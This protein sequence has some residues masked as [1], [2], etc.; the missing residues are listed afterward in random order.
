MSRYDCSV[1][2][3]A[4]IRGTALKLAAEDLRRLLQSGSV[5]RET[6]VERFGDDS[7]LLLQG[8][9]D[10]VAW[11]PIDLCAR[12]IAVLV[13]R[14]GGDDPI[15]YLQV[16]GARAAEVTVK[17]NYGPVFSEGSVEALSDE[18]MEAG[19]SLGRMMTHLGP[20][21]VNFGTWEFSFVDRDARPTFRFSGSAALPE[22]VRQ[23]T[24]GFIQ[25][26]STRT[27]GRPVRVDSE[28]HGDELTYYLIVD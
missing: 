28:R 8:E 21:I 15:G 6:L 26:L 16:R 11:Y 5:D 23:T 17:G 19:R 14:E 22:E 24:A 18:D 25:A 10:P 7:E 20:A 27:L 1:S 12:V 13:E 2:S 4:S 3:R 9:I